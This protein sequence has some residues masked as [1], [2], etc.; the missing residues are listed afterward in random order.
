MKISYEKQT[1]ASE[2]WCTVTQQERV[3]FEE[4]DLECERAG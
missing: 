3:I 4:E 2:C 1:P